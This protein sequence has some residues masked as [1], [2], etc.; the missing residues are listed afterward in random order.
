LIA[1]GTSGEFPGELSY[2]G[3]DTLA[4]LV[5]SSGSRR[6]MLLHAPLL[7]NDGAGVGGS[8]GDGGQAG[9]GGSGGAGGT[10]GAPG[11]LCT[12]CTLKKLDVPA[13]RMIHDRTNARLYAVLTYDA[14]H[15]PN[16]LVSVD[17]TAETVLATVPI[18]PSPRQLALSD[19]GATLW[20]G[21]DQASSIRKISVASTPPVLG[22]AYSLPPPSGSG[23]TSPIDMVALPG[24]PTSIAACFGVFGSARV[25]ILDDGVARPTIDATQ[26]SVSILA[27][28]PAGTLFG[29]AGTTSGG[30]FTSYAVSAAGVTK[31]FDMAGLVGTSP[32][33]HYHQGRVYADT[34]A[35]IDVADPAQPVR[36]G[37]FAFR[38]RIAA[39]S[40]NRMLMLTEGASTGS[41]QLRILETENFTQVAALPI[42]TNV[43]DIS[44]VTGFVYLGGDGVA[45]VSP[46]G[47]FIFRSP[48]IG[49]AP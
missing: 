40:S 18:D 7:A 33:I 4:L 5:G 39:R 1:G 14:A 45:F 31:L 35:V 3:G 37:K 9:R 38:G 20:V 42:G 11:S 16:S 8:G 10:G 34:G 41:L 6:L 22:G 29:Y 46:A 23:T 2:L 13:F 44:S 43:V 48:T 25:G 12:G 27:A 30:N 36:I 32:N 19:D 49:A 17:T 24:S 21:F 15:D 26:T 28:G 47:L